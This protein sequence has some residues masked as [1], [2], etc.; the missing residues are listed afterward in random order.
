MPKRPAR[1][2]ISACL[3]G[4]PVRYDG[5]GLAQT[6]ALLARWQAAGLLVPICPE[7][8]G[9]LGVPRPAAELEAGH[10]GCD[11]LAGRAQVRTR[12]GQDQSEAFVRGAEAALALAQR[13]GCRFAVL[14]ERSPSCGSSQ[15]YDGGFGGRLRAG[16]GVTTALL[17]RHGLRVFG[18]HQLAELAAWLPPG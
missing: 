15:L 3:L 9:G 7:L 6:D 17:R 5:R 4:Q 14:T 8:A 13:E 16:E 2:L 1:I 18:Q 10:Q 11:V 12:E